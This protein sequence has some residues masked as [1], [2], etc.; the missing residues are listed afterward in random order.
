MAALTIRVW[1]YSAKREQ[2]ETLIENFVKGWSHKVSL[3]KRPGWLRDAYYLSSP[4]AGLLR[5]FY[6][7]IECEVMRDA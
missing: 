2:V 7:K 6:S 5:L 1:H 3:D 4:D